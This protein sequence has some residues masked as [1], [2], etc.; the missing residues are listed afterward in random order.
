LESMSLVQISPH[1]QCE[2]TEDGPAITLITVRSWPGAERQANI[3]PKENVHVM[4]LGNLGP[5]LSQ[6]EESS[7]SVYTDKESLQH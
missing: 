7:W 6:V 2:L 5:G 1:D 4:R 3:D